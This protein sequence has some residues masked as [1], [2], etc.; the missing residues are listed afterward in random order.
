MSIQIKKQHSGLFTRNAIAISFLLVSVLTL[1]E[2]AV[3]NAFKIFWL[4]ESL[5]FFMANHT[6]FSSLFM[7]ALKT[8]PAVMPVPFMEYWL[9]FRL[10]ESALPLDFVMTHLEFILRFP[11]IVYMGLSVGCVY[12]MN[13]RLS[14]S[15]FIA[16]LFTCLLLLF[17]SLG[18]HLGAEVR[19]HTSGFMHM[20]LSWFL[21]TALLTG[22][23]KN[24]KQRNFIMILW[25]ISS[26]LTSWSHIY[27]I[28][29]S[30]LQFG[31]VLFAEFRL[32]PRLTT[33]NIKVPVK[34]F[35]YFLV[36]GS[37]IAAAV[38]FRF[39]I[40]QPYFR[41]ERL[42]Q[43]WESFHQCIEALSTYL[44]IPNFWFWVVI[45]VLLS[46]WGFTRQSQL[47][48]RLKILFIIG[49]GF[50]QF[51]IMILLTYRYFKIG[52]G[53]DAWV[54]RYSMAGI[55]P[56][57]FCLSYL[58]FGLI[59]PVWERQFGL[60]SAVVFLGVFL[61]KP[62]LNTSYWGKRDA[63]EESHWDNIRRDVIQTHALGKV[64]YVMGLV[65]ERSSTNQKDIHGEGVDHTWQLYTVGPFQIADFKTAYITQHG[66]LQPLPCKA[67]AILPR[68]MSGADKYAVDFCE[69]G[70]VILRSL[71]IPK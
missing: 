2:W 28:Y 5:M 68:A 52:W 51:V 40:T 33:K 1:W 16:A 55:I 34:L 62:G 60:V 46:F 36:Y 25:A 21:L 11:L 22:S 47:R 27:G 69:K 39:A 38:F 26:C 4:D 49:L 35:S 43:G 54:A 29:S 70:R 15:N 66:G 59:K 17:S 57:M 18:Q 19:F 24:E 10:L 9:Y 32:L 45:F 64:R 48:E 6:P 23:G 56:L 3:Q 65:P 37:V 31:L 53:P 67:R 71:I 12:L 44:L 30:V 8:M 61:L 7:M 42:K 20:S 58:S 41:D 50:L 63:I 13:L 14:R